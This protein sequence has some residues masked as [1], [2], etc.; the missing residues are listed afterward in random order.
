MK[1]DI[2]TQWFGW[3]IHQLDVIIKDYVSKIQSQAA[4]LSLYGDAIQFL[5][6]MLF[7]PFKV[8]YCQ[9]STQNI[10]AIIIST[11]E[12]VNFTIKLQ[13]RFKNF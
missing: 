3:R 10:L 8:H 9:N 12:K 11:V 1:G 2:L 7:I 5:K 13:L 6:S 4:F